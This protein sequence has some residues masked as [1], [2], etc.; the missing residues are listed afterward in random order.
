MKRPLAVFGF[1]LFTVLLCLNFIGNTVLSVSLAVLSGIL[2]IICTVNKKLRQSLMLPTVF[3]AVIAGCLFLLLFEAHYN[4]TVS[5]SGENVTVE[6]VVSESPY[7]SPENKRCYCVI[8]VR[9]LSE[10]RVNTKMRLSFSE[11]RDG[12]DC[13]NLDIGNKITFIGTVYPMG[14]FNE[15]Y[16]SY[17][18]SQAIYLGAYGI[19]NITVTEP[20]YKPLSFYIDA[21]R[22]SITEN[23]LHDFDNDVAT[24]LIALLTGDKSLMEDGIYDAF[25]RSGVVHIM[26]VS[27]LHLTIW[28]MFLSFFIDFKGRKG[29]LMSLLMIVFTLFMLNFAYYTGS[30]KR[31]GTMTILTFVGSFLGKKSDSLNSLGFAAICVLLLNPFAVLDISFML[32]FLSTLGIIVF[33]LPLSD[34]FMKQLS[35]KSEIIKSLIKPFVLSFSISVCVSFIT[36]PAVVYY[37]GGVSLA[38]PIT[39]MLLLFAGTPLI[40]L[41]GIYSFLRF[42]PF[43][44][45]VVAVI[46]KYLSLYMLR[47]TEYIGSFKLSYISTEEVWVRYLITII[48]LII[49]SGSLLFVFI[50]DFK[51]KDKI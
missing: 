23:L 36:L 17:Y 38:A 8:K 19:D 12:I 1:T 35:D 10:E 37:F 27:G 4:E 32:S 26:A 3:A 20:E 24:L 47:V 45:S 18:K 48:A 2:F 33:A 42:V 11:S 31:A 9:S 15:A 22:D 46:M 51:N 25:K 34:R 13:K 29:K 50:R 39:N 7:F 49:I 28:V 30:V 41:T 16:K 43:V 14:S 44:S 40:L 6:G 21:L 5:Y